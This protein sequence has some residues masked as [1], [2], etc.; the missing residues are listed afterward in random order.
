MDFVFLTNM[1]DSE[2][3]RFVGPL[4]RFFGVIF[5]AIFELFNNDVTRGFAL[6]IAIII[7]TFLMLTLVLPLSMKSHKSMM[8]MHRIAPE[9]DAVKKKYEGKTDVE[10][11]RKMQIEIQQLYSKNKINPLMGCLPALLTLPVFFGLNF[12]MRQIHLYIRYIGQLYNDIAAHILQ[13]VPRFDA[14]GARIEENISFWIDSVVPMFP[15]DFVSYA[16]GYGPR[17]IVEDVSRAVSNFTAEQ[18]YAVQNLIDDPEKLYYLN[19]LLERRDNV[20][21]FLGLNM[22]NNAGFFG[23]GVIIPILAV[24]TTFISSYLMQR[25]QRSKDPA[26]QMQQRIMLYGMPLFM[27]FITTSMAIGVGFYWVTSNVYRIGQH[28]VLTKYYS[29]REL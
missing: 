17:F 25:S 29:K 26:Q 21:T 5:N 3:G 23:I 19:V 13:A 15:S 16:G 18:W 10:N 12:I 14:V 24:I 11:K 8:K 2:P 1:I 4:A 9:V 22:S 7:L 20:I 6:G 28:Y 27:G